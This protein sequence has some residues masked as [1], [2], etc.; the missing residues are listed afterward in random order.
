MKGMGMP[1]IIVAVMRILPM[2]SKLK[3]VAN[4]LPYEAAIMGNFSLPFKRAASVMTPSLV[5]GGEKSPLEMRQAVRAV[6]GAIPNAQH[7]MLEGQSH[8]VSM[9]ALAR[10]L[11]EFFK[12]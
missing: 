11:E 1:A 2:W 4:T 8:N 7:R 9:K 3:A 12:A 10:V 5:I 6:A